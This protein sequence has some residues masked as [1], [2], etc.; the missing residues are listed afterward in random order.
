MHRIFGRSATSA[1]ISA[2]LA[3]AMLCAPL[4]AAAVPTTA[5]IRAKQ[6]E[7]HLDE[8][9]TQVAEDNVVTAGR[10]HRV[11]GQRPGCTREGMGESV[12]GARPG[13]REWR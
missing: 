8:A 9:V 11:K 10:C 13:A 3:V 7:A 2:V 5:K 6:A 12:A 4:S 1:L